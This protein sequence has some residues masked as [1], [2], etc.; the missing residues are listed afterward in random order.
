MIPEPRQSHTT[1]AVIDRH[2]D[3]SFGLRALKQKLFVDGLSYLLQEIYGIENKNSEINKVCKS[4][5]SIISLNQSCIPT[6]YGNILFHQIY[7]H[8]YWNNAVN[9]FWYVTIFWCIVFDIMTIFLWLID[10]AL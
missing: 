8:Y 10:R 1:I 9:I 2:T 5:T 7:M 3:G 4:L 6:V